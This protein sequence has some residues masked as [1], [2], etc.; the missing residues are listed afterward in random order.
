MTMATNAF[1]IDREMAKK[2]SDSGLGTIV[3]SLNSLDEQAHDDL[4]GIK[5][6]YLKRGMLSLILPS[7]L[8]IPEYASVLLYVNKHYLA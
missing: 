2:V 7:R 3:I 5:G 1:L 8:V 4:K 6:S